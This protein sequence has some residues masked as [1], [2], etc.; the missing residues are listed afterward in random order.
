MLVLLTPVSRG[1]CLVDFCGERVNCSNTLAEE[2]G[3][4]AVRGLPIFPCAH[5][6]HYHASQTYHEC[7]QLLGVLEVQ[8]HTHASV[9]VVLPQRSRISNTTSKW[10]CSPRKTT[11][12]PLFSLTILPVA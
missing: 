6:T 8:L 2:A 10:S 4:A 12:L 3:L 11:V 9:V 7:V 1:H 5:H